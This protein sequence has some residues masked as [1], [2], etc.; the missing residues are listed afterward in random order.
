MT[1]NKK[2]S[3]SMNKYYQQHDNNINYETIVATTTATSDVNNTMTSSS[4][5][6]PINPQL[7][8]I[9]VGKTGGST[10]VKALSLSN[11][12]TSVKCMVRRTK[13]KTTRR[14]KCYKYP[15]NNATS[16]LTQSILGVYHTWSPLLNK[17]DKLWLL[18]NTNIF[19][20]TIRNP[21][22]RLQSAY[23]YHKDGTHTVIKQN[24]KR[25]TYKDVKQYFYT[26][27]Y[28]NGFN[29]MITKLRTTGIHKTTTTVN[30]DNMDDDDCYTIGRNVL[31]GK[32]NQGDVHFQYNYEYYYTYTLSN[33]YTEHTHALAVV[34][35]EYL[36][37]DVIQLNQQ[38]GGDDEDSSISSKNYWN[39]MKGYKVTHGS[40]NYTTHHHHPSSG[41]DTEEIISIP[42]AIY[43]CC[44]MY[45]EIEIYQ[46]LLLKAGNLS[47]DQKRI[48]LNEL[49]TTCHVTNNTE[50]VLSNPFSWTEYN[51]GNICEGVY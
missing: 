32:S 36:W 42:N 44:L 13:T 35:T 8:L 16:K 20:F 3:P 37:E 14:N 11:Y 41:N 7:Y 51:K 30:D 28:S 34:R 39:T 6:P 26:H 18:Q 4:S 29:N 17:A 10:I 5:W 50:D 45:N 15:S 43:L 38:L 1:T 19:L 27:C 25:N 46:L 47:D 49:L 33:Q 21:I 40:E 9:H 12:S 24:G 23:N 31:L 2:E 22:S 48:S